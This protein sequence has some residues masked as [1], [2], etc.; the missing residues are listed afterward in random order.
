MLDIQIMKDEAAF[1]VAAAWEII[2]QMLRKP[3]SVIGLSTGQ[4]TKNM[5]AIVRDV[6]RQYPF[7]TSRVTLFNVDELTNLPRSY[8]GCCYTM[9]QEQI[10]G[11]LGIPE[12]RFL[13]PA[14]L[15]DDYEAEC[16]AFQ[17]A[18]EE[19]GGADLQMLGLGYNGHIGINQPGTPFGSETW[20]SPMD[21][22]FEERVR[23]ET[24]VGPEH[25]LGGL[26]LGIR[27]IMHAR[28]IVLIAKGAHKAEMVEKMLKGPVTEE[29]PA[30]VLQ[31]HPNCTF[32]LDAEAGR[33]VADMEGVRRC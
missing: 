12:E 19:R 14:T 23:R 10:A 31:L 9:I 24:G 20:V 11:P 28:R 33:Y 6:Y 4:T 27:T 7:D 15:S 8:A 32:L 5:H 29:I 3:D 30:S 21:P 1:D 25:E 17:R 18:I 2:G 22:I 26:T 13:M 16:T